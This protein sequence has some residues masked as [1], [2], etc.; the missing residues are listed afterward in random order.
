MFAYK[1]SWI[2][3]FLDLSQGELLN[4][5][6][7]WAMWVNWLSSVDSFNPR[8]TSAWRPCH[9]KIHLLLDT[10]SPIVA[11][12][13]SLSN[14]FLSHNGWMFPILAQQ[15]LGSCKW[16]N[17]LEHNMCNLWVLVCMTKWN[18]RA[19]SVQWGMQWSLQSWGKWKLMSSNYID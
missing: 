8:L 17:N 13:H 18:Y 7:G 15:H 14:S 5:A 16:N 6:L 11:H 2:K 12:C 10:N 19:L 4:G 1:Q 9:C 3:F